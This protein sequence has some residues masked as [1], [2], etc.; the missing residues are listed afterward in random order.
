MSIFNKNICDIYIERINLLTENSAPNWG[1][2]DVAAMLLH[3][4]K[5]MEEP[6]GR[7]NIFSK[8]WL[9]WTRKKIAIGDKP[10]TPGL[11]NPKVFSIANTKGFDYERKYLIQKIEET[12]TN[13]V[14]F[15]EG[16]R[17]P[18]FGKLSAAQWSQ[19]FLKH[20]DHHLRQFGV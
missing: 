1:R 5:A 11:P 19:F 7:L 3:C 13:G 18:V 12:R 15:Y 17:H 20:L 8:L 14:A 2:M 4:A 6:R 9:R 16:R 10:Y